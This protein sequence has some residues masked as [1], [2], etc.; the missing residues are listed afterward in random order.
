M[1]K[2]AFC[3]R[4]FCISTRRNARTDSG[5]ALVEVMVGSLILVIVFTG[6]VQQISNLASARVRIET[7][8]RAVTYINSLHQVMSA[9]GCGLDV[10]TVVE[11]TYTQEASQDEYLGSDQTRLKG[12]WDRVQSC[13][14]SALEKVR[15]TPDA[16]HVNSF[17]D[18]TGNVHLTVNDN[19]T[20]SSAKIDKTTA[21]KFCKE[22]GQAPSQY[23]NVSCEMGDQDFQ[24]KVSVNDEGVQTIFDVSV[25][26]W[27]EIVGGDNGVVT[28]GINNKSTCSQVIAAQKMPDTIARKVS[29]TFPNAKG[30]TETI[31]VTKRENVPVD[32]FQF[33]SGTRVAIAGI[34]GDEITMYPSPGVND[35]FKVTRI[36][37][38][39]TSCIWFPYIS[40][41]E[42]I[43]KQPVFSIDGA[44]AQQATLTDIAVLQTGQL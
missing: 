33:A 15:D 35:P 43:D 28:D 24:H 38:N 16:T 37:N 23:S 29:V 40:R 22:Y 14:F 12:P 31:S 9:A 8:D 32:S 27:F 34:N 11:Q 4:P 2:K 21:A 13:A 7:R 10:D 17:L 1:G 39:S 44:G 6:V 3:R 36:R 25:R 19:G 42:Q 18:D 26:Y 5:A 20:V 41:H 30:G